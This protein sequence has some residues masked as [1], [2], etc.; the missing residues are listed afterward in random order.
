MPNFTSSNQTAAFFCEQYAIGR[1]TWWRLSNRADF[2]KPIRIG[3]SV[4]WSVAAVAAYFAKQNE[5]A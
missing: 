4:R 1:T 2:V 3:R 5:A